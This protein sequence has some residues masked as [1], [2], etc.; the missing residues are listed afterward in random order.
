MLSG[1][2]LKV[3][4]PFSNPFFPPFLPAALLLPLIITIVLS[5][6]NI[7]A[8]LPNVS[9]NVWD[10]PF[11]VQLLHAKQI[12]LLH[13]VFVTTFTSTHS[14][15]PHA[16][17]FHHDAHFG[18]NW[19]VHWSQKLIWGRVEWQGNDKWE[20]AKCGAV[21]E[22]LINAHDLEKNF[23]S[24]WRIC[25]PSMPLVPLPSLVPSKS[26]PQFLLK[27]WL[28][29]F[30]LSC[31]LPANVYLSVSSWGL[32]WLI[33]PAIGIA[34]SIPWQRKRQKCSVIPPARYL[35]TSAGHSQVISSVVIITLSRWVF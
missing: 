17:P 27:L 9:E 34:H 12:S 22:L 11:Y 23:S 14:S 35:G 13:F 16:T 18:G 10:L 24:Y 20:L 7:W 1:V 4:Y 33:W 30:Q 31:L 29:S 5:S 32:S 21:I 15:V 8:S 26:T 3:W 25:I 2:P 6:I 28:C 19:L